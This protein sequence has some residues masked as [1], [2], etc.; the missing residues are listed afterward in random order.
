MESVF[1]YYEFSE[2]M[3]DKSEAFS[4]NEICFSI[5][6]EHH[7]L[8]FEKKKEAYK[9]YVSKYKSKL[10]V[11][12]EQPEILELLVNDYDKSKP[13]HRIILRKYLY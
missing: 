12:F 13:E 1:R 8:I 10:E 6:N 11:G 3:S 4:G 5:L 7:F 9:L 2:F